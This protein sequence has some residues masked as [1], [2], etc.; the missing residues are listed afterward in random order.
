MRESDD[1][2]AKEMLKRN[3]TP[4]NGLLSGSKKIHKAKADGEHV[5]SPETGKYSV[6]EKGAD[7][8]RKN[9]RPADQIQRMFRCPSEYCNKS[10]G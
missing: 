2:K 6:Q 3:N 9:R 10:Y 7:K 1:D 8:K 4:F 5:Q